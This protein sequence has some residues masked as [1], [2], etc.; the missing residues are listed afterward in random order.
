[1]D[2]ASPENQTL[3]L[4]D[5]LSLPLVISL[6]NGSYEWNMFFTDFKSTPS[7]NNFCH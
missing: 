1:L 2:L 5:V 4:F 7:L 6:T 3:T